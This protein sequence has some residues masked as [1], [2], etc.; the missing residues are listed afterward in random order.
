MHFLPQP[1]KTITQELFTYSAMR[2]GA[3]RSK[4]GRT[5]PY[6]EDEYSHMGP[7][8]GQILLAAMIEN[9]QLAADI[10]SSRLVQ[11]SAASA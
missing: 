9:Q 11:P 5:T 7:E 2:D 3:L 4:D 10:A 8:Y 1:G 6:A